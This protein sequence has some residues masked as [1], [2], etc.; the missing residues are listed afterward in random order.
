VGGELVLN[1]ARPFF[2]FVLRGI[3]SAA[4]IKDIPRSRLA[5]VGVF[6]DVVFLF[7]LHLILFL[8]G[9][10]RVFTYQIEPDF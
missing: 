8:L 7:L 3:D 5:A 10:N 4:T 9:V 6:I 1:G 2:G